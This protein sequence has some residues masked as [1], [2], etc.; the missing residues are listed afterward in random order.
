MAGRRKGRI[1]AFQ[2]LYAWD[3]AIRLQKQKQVSTV[4]VDGLLEFGWI[5]PERLERY[6][7]AT[8]TFARLLCKG[9]IENRKII[10]DTIR[11]KLINWEFSRINRVDLAILRLSIYTLHFQKDTHPTIVIDEAIGLAKEF[12]GE[13]S[14]RFINGILDKIRID[15]TGDTGKEQ[16]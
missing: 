12:S 5:E 13:D 3:H 4:D 9:T 2:A 11:S 10:Y 16:P 15:G 8:L 6:G 7:D 1:L 14:F